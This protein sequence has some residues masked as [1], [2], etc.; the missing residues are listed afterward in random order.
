MSEG[1][2]LTSGE[3][4]FST[5]RNGAVGVLAALTLGVAFTLAA[6]TQGAAKPT[7]RFLPVKMT[8]PAPSGARNLCGKYLWACSV[9]GVSDR[10]TQ[11]DIDEVKRVNLRVNRQTRSIEDQSQYRKADYWTLP[12]RRG[13]DCEDFALLKKKQLIQVGIA[14]ERLLIATV[15]DR[16]GNSH[17][18]LVLRADTGD[19]VLDNLTNKIKSWQETRYM[20]LRMQSPDRANAWVGVLAKG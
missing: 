18:V 12:S 11:S 1:F 20:F 15:L 19:Y 10:L 5:I 16:N 3:I 8:I 7:E 9:S 13:G 17:A 6:P 14:P 4:N 2:R